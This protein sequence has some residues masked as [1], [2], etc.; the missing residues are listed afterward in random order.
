[1]L[2]MQ[3]GLRWLKREVVTLHATIL[4]APSTNVCTQVGFFGGD[5]DR[6]TIHGQSSGGQAVELHYVMP[7]SKG[8]LQGIISESGG[9]GAGSIESGLKSSKALA[10]AI[11][12]DK[13]D[14]HEVSGERVAVALLFPALHPVAHVS[15]ALSQLK[16]CVQKSPALYITS[17]T[18][19]FS[20]SPVVDNVRALHLRPRTTHIVTCNQPACMQVT[21]TEDPDRSL[22]A[23]RINPVAVI[24]GAQTNDS[25]KELLADYEDAYGTENCCSGHS[26]CL[27]PLPMRLLSVRKRVHFPPDAR[28]FAAYHC[29]G[30]RSAS[31]RG[32]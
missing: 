4:P 1:M 12:C 19:N 21:I 10:S 29:Q 30:V 17:L 16:S 7:G 26:L 20:F 3:S 8:L 31:G 28:A 27:L 5:P 9:L 18:Y 25:N 15:R 14:P 2:D 24:M 22:A 32:S 6:I 13:S 11:G 23:G